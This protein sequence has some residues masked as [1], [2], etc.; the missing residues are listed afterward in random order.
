MAFR[1]TPGYTEKLYRENHTA[2]QFLVFAVEAAKKL[3]LDIQ[4]LSQTGFVAF[5]NKGLMKWNA[6][7]TFKLENDYALITSESVGAE[8]YSWGRNKKMVN[9]FYD[10]FVSQKYALNTTD[11]DALYLQLQPSMVQ[12]EDDLLNEP[13]QSFPDKTKDFLSFFIPH[14]DFFVTPILIDL[15]I[16]IYVAM[17][18]SGVNFFLP[19]N[20]SLLS[21][22]ANFRSVTMDGEWWRLLTCCFVH[23]GILHLLMNMYA[24]LYIGLLL[25]PIIG[26]F[27]FAVTYLLTG[28][29]ASVASF[30]WH[31]VTI[32]AGASGAIFGLYGIFFALLLTNIIEKTAR[33]ALLSSIVIFI[34]FN[35]IN[36]ING[37]IDNAAHIGGLISGIIIGF[38]CYPSLAK[39]ELRTRNYLINTAVVLLSVIVSVLLIKSTPNTIAEF[40]KLMKEFGQK[41]QTAIHI[42]T[43]PE[44]TPDSTFL[45]IIQQETLPNW[46]EC[47]KIVS[48]M[49]AID[50]ISDAL[51][52]RALLLDK[53]CDYR[54]KLF[55][56][57]EYAIEHGV[58]INEGEVATYNA[59]IEL[60]MRKMQGEEV[61]EK[62]FKEI[63]QQ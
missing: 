6:K 2:Q 29:L 25:E 41:E 30:W 18:C 27:K 9:T 58:E 50:P 17:V 12:P 33:K 15:N 26:K 60:L 47:K 8:L 34:L 57:I 55:K 1:L 46:F 3:E 14:K 35:L 62:A 24:L 31:D 45:R 32:S 28:I 49:K 42:F 21:W 40:D 5:T 61:D 7:I 20:E 39:P 52:D 19:D 38:A 10:E 36:G 44:D 56:A 54:I 37:N 59:N 51:L 11:T 23:I 13:P 48:Q 63:M 22:G 43:V 53:Y 16:L 4:F